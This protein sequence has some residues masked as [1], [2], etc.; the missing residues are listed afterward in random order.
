MPT[1]PTLVKA[2]TSIATMAVGVLVVV[3]AAGSKSALAEVA[4]EAIVIA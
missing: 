2:T 4:N 1:E 3:A